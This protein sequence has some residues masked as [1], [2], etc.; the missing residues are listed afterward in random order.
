MTK[1]GKARV[2]TGALMA[3]AVGAILIRNS[4]WRPDSAGTFIPSIVQPKPDPT[5]QDTIYAMFDAAREGDIRGY[6]GHYTG[7]MLASLQQTVTEQGES[8]FGKYL[9]E[10]N[11]PVKG[12]AIMEPQPAADRAVTLRVEYVYADRNEVQMFHLEKSGNNWKIARV[13]TAER[14]KTLVPY[15]TPVQ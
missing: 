6:V 10:S 2:L 9:K 13:D 11:A 8:N 7:Q 14:I 12:I 15:G 5:P 3:G 4:G 1:Q